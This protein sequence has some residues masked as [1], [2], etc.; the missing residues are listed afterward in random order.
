[1]SE[2]CSADDPNRCQGVTPH[3]QCEYLAV[4]GSDRCNYHSRGKAEVNLA[5]AKKERYLIDNEQIR[6]AYLRLRGDED[7]LDL[8]EEI[9][10]THAMIERRLNAIKTDADAIMAI[11]HYTQLIQRLESMKISLMKLQQQ[12]GMVLNKESIFRLA[13]VFAQILD[14]ELDNIEDKEERM[15]RLMERLVTAIEAAGKEK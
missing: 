3:G 1:M 14:E 9:D 2:K 8:K 15:D 13:G 5:K 6:K 10:L 4:E 7:Y 11:G 12:M